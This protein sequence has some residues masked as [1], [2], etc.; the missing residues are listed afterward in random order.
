V[1]DRPT[2]GRSTDADLVLVVARQAGADEDA[3]SSASTGGLLDA[4][5]QALAGAVDAV[6]SP[7]PLDRIVD[8]SGSKAISI[9]YATTAPGDLEMAVERLVRDGANDLL[10]VPVAV[11]VGEGPAPGSSLAGLDERIDRLADRL[12]S[13]ITYVG[14][15]FDDPPALAAVLERL[16]RNAA[17]SAA[18][19]DDVV[20][21]V[22]DGQQARL[23]GVVA[24]IQKAVPPG[25]RIALRGSA[26]TGEAYRTG[27]PFDA[28]GPRTS[29]LDVVL[30]GEDAMAEWE[31][32]GF[33]FPGVNTIP[34]SDHARWA[35]PRLEPARAAVQ[36]LAG[37][38]VTFQAM[39]GWFLELRSTLQGTPHVYLDA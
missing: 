33:Y 27:L 21:R 39:A 36:E 3:A 11:A 2:E 12:P 9:A 25:T 7:D 31:P 4:I 6:A 19:I 16:D 34:L 8:S 15:P 5:R 14:P 20:E 13:R 37:R 22:F 17:N 38:P 30:V 10:V 18:L 23:A 24:E 26:V 35:A 29:D 32:E 1:P 28:R